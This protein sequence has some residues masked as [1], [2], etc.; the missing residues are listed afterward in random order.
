MGLEENARKL[1]KAAEREGARGRSPQQK[2]AAQR[3]SD[4]ETAKVHPRITNPKHRK[5]K[6]RGSIPRVRKSPK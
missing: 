6:P 3:E 1:R 5:G 4:A 2:K